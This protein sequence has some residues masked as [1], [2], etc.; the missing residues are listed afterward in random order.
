MKLDSSYLPLVLVYALAVRI[1]V[2]PDWES[3]VAFIAATAL[4]IFIQRKDDK[5]TKE[6]K[7][8]HDEV[9]AL[10]IF[11]SIRKSL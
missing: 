10:K 3:V 8:M 5:L 7:Q 1:V 11:A 6:L 9:D 2:L 4:A